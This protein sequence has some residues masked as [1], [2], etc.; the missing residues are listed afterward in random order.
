[1]SIL[2]HVKTDKCPV[3]GCEHVIKECIETTSYCGD[4][5]I[6]IHTNGTRTERREFLCGFET[7]YVPN[8]K[9]E[10]VFTACK[11]DPE[12]VARAEKRKADKEL[13][14]KFIRE[15]TIDWDVVSDVYFGRNY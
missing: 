10:N 9:K 15:N 4:R 1:M 6:F 5:K 12:L 3:C 14:T 8:F 7:I 2:N 11:R 13:L